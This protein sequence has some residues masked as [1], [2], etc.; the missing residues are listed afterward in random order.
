[1]NARIGEDV[2]AKMVTLHRANV[3][4]GK[5]IVLLGT[6]VNMKHMRDACHR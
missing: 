6:K 2:D 5:P 3:L 1:M 4:Y